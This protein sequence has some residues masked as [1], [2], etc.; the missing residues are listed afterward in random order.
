MPDSGLRYFFLS[1]SNL[2]NPA[3][4]LTLL[5]YY[6]LEFYH[7]CNLE[8]YVYFSIQIC[9]TANTFYVDTEPYYLC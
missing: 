4:L 5:S 3:S 1:I 6:F 2:R 8:F 7:F 9:L